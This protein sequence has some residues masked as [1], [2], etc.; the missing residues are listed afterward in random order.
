MQ[1]QQ[2]VES[3]YNVYKNVVNNFEYDKEQSYN[4]NLLSFQQHVNDMLPNGNTTEVIDFTRLSL[5]VNKDK[6]LQS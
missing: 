4:N 5:L 3:D 1:P 2:R 6:L